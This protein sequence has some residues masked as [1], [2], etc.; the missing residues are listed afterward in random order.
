MATDTVFEL[1]LALP[2]RGARN[3]VRELHGQ[4]RAAIF[5]GR[6]KPGLQLPPSRHLAQALDVSRN[7]VVC[8]YDLLLS[9]GYLTAR[10]GSGTFVADVPQ[11]PATPPRREPPAPDPRLGPAWRDLPARRAP[12][13][14]GF[15]YDFRIGLPDQG[16]A[17]FDIWRRLSDRA[18]RAMARQGPIYTEPEGG[19]A[20]REAVARH[21]AFARAVSCTADDIVVTNG[22]QQAFDLIARIL[23]TP[24]E[25]TVAVEDPGYA[26]LRAAFARAGAILAPTPVD[27]EGLVVD[28][29]PS[30][31]RVICVTPSHQFPLGVPMS[32]ARRAA[33]LA[34]A[35]A[36]GALILEDDYDSEFRYGGRPLEALQTLDRDACVFYVGTFSKSLFPALR[37]GYVAGPAWA[38]PALVEA[39][40]T[41]D[42]R[43]A[44]LPQETLAA[45][46]AEGHLA[47]HVRRMRKLYGARREILLDA[48][49][50]RLGL[51][52]LPSTAGLH[53]AVELPDH[54]DAEA[55]AR[56]AA[57]A[58]VGLVP[59]SRYAVSRPGRNGLVFGYGLIEADRIDEGVRRL[60]QALP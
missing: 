54:L 24:G 21:A 53:L 13:P 18:L 29:L 41:T 15:A 47:R 31:A 22:A 39:R 5:D 59:L 49:N 27:A 32:P 26:P 3:R 45:F 55:L 38:R 43:G 56:H 36:R 14:V 60:A 11:R 2:P 42:G 23:V 34:F 19:P 25:T 12:S 20:L 8:V 7:A 10:T 37:L 40:R 1:A 52:P 16:Q 33:L 4:L 28:A 48:L 30:D 35:R 9:E 46:I 51:A 6:L 17:P 57:D 44:F 50:R 58:G